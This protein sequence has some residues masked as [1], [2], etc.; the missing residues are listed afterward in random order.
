MLACAWCDKIC[1]HINC[2]ALS[3]EKQSDGNG[4]HHHHKQQQHDRSLSWTCQLSNLASRWDVTHRVVGQS[5]SSSPLFT[6]ETL[7][8]HK[9]ALQ[10]CLPHSRKEKVACS[11]SIY[12]ENNM[13]NVE[14]FSSTEKLWNSTACILKDCSP[15]HRVHAM[16][17]KKRF[18]LVLTLRPEKCKQIP[19]YLHS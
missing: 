18:K 9:P 7:S 5:W 14:Q 13:Q 12:P 15:V 16:C 11:I 1:M 4:S 8:M 3:Q 19:V 10:L 6:C 17:T 2:V